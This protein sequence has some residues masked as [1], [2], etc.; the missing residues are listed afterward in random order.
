[1]IVARFVYRLAISGPLK[2]VRWFVEFGW[3]LEGDWSVLICRLRTIILYRTILNKSAFSWEKSTPFKHKTCVGWQ[4]TA[5]QP[6]HDR[7]STPPNSAHKQQQQQKTRSIVHGGEKTNFSPKIVN[8]FIYFVLKWL[9]S[10]GAHLCAN[11]ARKRKLGTQ[12]NQVNRCVTTKCKWFFELKIPLKWHGT[13]TAF[14]YFFSRPQSWCWWCWWWESHMQIKLLMSHSI[15]FEE[16]MSVWFRCDEFAHFFSVRLYAV[17]QFGII[18]DEK[19]KHSINCSMQWQVA[20]VYWN[21]KSMEW[22]VN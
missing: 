2:I 1:M 16:E 11:K 14:D 21:Q 10:C 8:W 7:N 18:V 15:N 22:L 6:Q 3:V 13:K 19:N 17:M 9:F 20:K 12:Q 5:Q 4:W